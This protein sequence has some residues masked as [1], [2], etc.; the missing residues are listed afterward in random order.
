MEDELADE[1]LQLKVDTNKADNL[2][3]L[4]CQ[5]NITCIYFL[6]NVGDY[7]SQKKH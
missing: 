5:K 6:V 1:W 2:S 3:E 4:I 7:L